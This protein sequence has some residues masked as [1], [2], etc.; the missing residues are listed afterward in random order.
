MKRRLSQDI[1]GIKNQNK[2]CLILRS[3]FHITDKVYQCNRSQVL[4][5]KKH[6]QRIIYRKIATSPVHIYSYII[7]PPGNKYSP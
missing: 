7:L 2:N 1:C 3:K 6:S 4:P 5:G